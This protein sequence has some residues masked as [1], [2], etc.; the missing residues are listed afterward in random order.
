M[1]VSARG[2]YLAQAFNDNGWPISHWDLICAKM[3]HHE[4]KP[5]ISVC[6]FNY[7]LWWVTNVHSGNKSEPARESNLEF[8]IKCFRKSH[9]PQ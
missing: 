8:T 7:D 6:Y 9:A 4:P 1:L 5:S 2:F 3:Q